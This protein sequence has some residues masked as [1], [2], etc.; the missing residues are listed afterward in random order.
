VNNLLPIHKLLVGNLDDVSLKSINSI[1]S[2]MIGYI[3]SKSHE[4]Y[5]LQFNHSNKTYILNIQAVKYIRKHVKFLQFKL[6]PPEILNY[7]LSF[8]IE[9]TITKF[10]QD[11]KINM[12]LLSPNNINCNG[13]NYCGIPQIPSIFA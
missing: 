8:I 7:I 5:Y 6:F 4:S 1:K 2:N 9:D 11:I 10:N 13:V 12:T 3:K